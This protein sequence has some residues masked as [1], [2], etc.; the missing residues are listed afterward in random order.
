MGWGLKQNYY[1]TP[2]FI[3]QRVYFNVITDL[4]NPNMIVPPL[5]MQINP[6]T[7]NQSFQKKIHR[8][9][10]FIAFIE[11]YWGDELDTISCSNSTGGFVLEPEDGIDHL[12]VCDRTKTISYF[13]FQDILD[14][15]RNNGNVYDSTGRIVKKGN[16]L[17]S[18][19]VG[20]YY[21]YFEN[22]NYTEDAESPYK[23]NFDFV[24]KVEKSYIGF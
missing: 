11:E 15:Y 13:K 6:H 21:G 19:D 10:T 12:T 17:L 16:I 3:A 18:F 20:V 22:F 9:T 5:Y 2:N 8:Y 4:L 1:S 24:F 14:L 7:F 23:F